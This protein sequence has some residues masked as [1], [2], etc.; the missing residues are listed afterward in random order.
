MC[1]CV[2]VR[3]VNVCEC[4]CECVCESVCVSV[5]ESGMWVCVDVWCVCV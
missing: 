1:E 4:E 3:C 5:C 2:C